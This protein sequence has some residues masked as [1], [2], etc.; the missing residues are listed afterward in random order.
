MEMQK[1]GEFFKYPE[2][3]YYAQG[4]CVHF[5]CLLLTGEGESPLGTSHSI[6][7]A[8]NTHEPAK[9]GKLSAAAGLSFTN[10]PLVGR[11]LHW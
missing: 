10:M 4:E 11:L 6:Y 7:P 9:W 2:N 8:R 1:E 3:I 5:T